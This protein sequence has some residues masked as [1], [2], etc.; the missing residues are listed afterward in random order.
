LPLINGRPAVGSGK[1]AVVSAIKNAYTIW[2]ASRSGVIYVLVRY[3]DG[4]IAR[5][6]T[7]KHRASCPASGTW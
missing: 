3:P 1:V 2:S 7:P 4:H 5:T 6:C